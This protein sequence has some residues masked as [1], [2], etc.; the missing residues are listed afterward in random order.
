MILISP[1]ARKLRSGKKHPKDYP[2]WSEVIQQIDEEIIQLGIE[3]EEQ[4]VDD[5]R[6]NLPLYELALLVAE[7]KTWIS[8]DSFLQHF[9]WDLHKPGIVIFGQSDP[10]IFGHNE[11]TNLLKDRLYLREKQFWLWE[12][13][14][15]LEESFVEPE[16]VLTALKKFDVKLK[17]YEPISV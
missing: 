17:D 11:N 14:E 4:L 10:K 5:F 15:Y 2:Y 3:G 12:Q 7:C 1:F 8:V 13:A 16:V 6:K 9:C